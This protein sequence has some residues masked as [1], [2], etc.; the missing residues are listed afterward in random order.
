MDLS[1]H[2]VTVIPTTLG[3]CLYMQISAPINET[4]ILFNIVKDM[5][6]T[7]TKVVS[8]RTMPMFSKSILQSRSMYI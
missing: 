3:K 8:M 7:V 1:S 4:P 6:G 5:H 2:G